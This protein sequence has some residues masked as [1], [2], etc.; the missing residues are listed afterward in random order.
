ML[1]NLDIS[2]I[3]KILKIDSQEVWW[4]NFPYPKN[5]R[6]I[7]IQE[8]Q[9]LFFDFGFCLSPIERYPCLAPVH[10]ERLIK[11]IGPAAECDERFTQRIKRRRGIFI[12]ASHAKAFDFDGTIYDPAGKISEIN[13]EELFLIKEAW[14]MGS[15][16]L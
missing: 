11:L 7:H 12:Y 14:I 5:L 6:G 9:D 1:L 8:I 4:K 3:E 2:E 10:D 16:T 13:K 15:L